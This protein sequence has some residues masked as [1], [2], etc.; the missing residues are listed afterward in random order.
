MI[1]SLSLNITKMLWTIKVLFLFLTVHKNW[2]HSLLHLWCLTLSQTGHTHNWAWQLC[3]C[4]HP[5]K[6]HPL[7]SY[8]KKKTRLTFLQRP[9][10]WGYFSIFYL[11]LNTMQ[12]HILVCLLRYFSTRIWTSS[13]LPDVAKLLSK[14]LISIYILTSIV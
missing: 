2:F 10:D 12:Q 6:P 4:P 1:H 7:R 8:L 11:L 13:A 5:P 9:E 3:N 14:E